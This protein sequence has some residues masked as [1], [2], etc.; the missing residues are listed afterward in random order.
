LV[1]K[2]L[3]IDTTQPPDTKD[4]DVH[5]GPMLDMRLASM[6]D[7]VD[8]ES[9]EVMVYVHVA[10]GGGFGARVTS[11]SGNPAVTPLI[12]VCHS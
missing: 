6:N 8:V 11:R 7:E 1:Q 5:A 10:A 2:Q 9:G 4:G 12:E 3:I